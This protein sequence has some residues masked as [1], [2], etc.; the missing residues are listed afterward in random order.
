MACPYGG[1]WVDWKSGLKNFRKN[2][3]K[4][5][6]WGL[7]KCEQVCYNRGVTGNHDQSDGKQ[8]S[9]FSADPLGTGSCCDPFSGAVPLFLHRRVII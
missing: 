5:F 9:V 2:I 4:K 1:L 8:V 7:D 6:I 3:R